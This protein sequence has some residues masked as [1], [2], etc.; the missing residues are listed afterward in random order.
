VFGDHN[1]PERDS[2]LHSKLDD[3]FSK[4]HLLQMAYVDLLSSSVVD[5]QP[6]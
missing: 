6:L 3:F 1:V 2:S 5:Y 4:I